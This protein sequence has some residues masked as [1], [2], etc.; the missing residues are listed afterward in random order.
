MLQHGGSGAAGGAAVSGVAG[1]G[2]AAGGA[3]AGRGAAAGGARRRKAHGGLA[4]L[5]ARLGAV[6]GEVSSGRSQLAA[7]QEVAGRQAQLVT[8]LRVQ[9]RPVAHLTSTV[10]PPSHTRSYAH[11]PIRPY[12]SSQTPD[13]KSRPPKPHVHVHVHVHVRY[14]QDISRRPIPRAGAAAAA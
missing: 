7:A 5:R 14:S 10:Q 1:S 6:C 3:A 2:A 12:A 13:P 9:V 11:T 8:A 4:A